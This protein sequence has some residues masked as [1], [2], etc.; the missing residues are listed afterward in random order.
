MPTPV[1]TRVVQIDPGPTPTLTM[2][3]PWSAQARTASPVATLPTISATCRVNRS[4]SL[5]GELEDPGRVAVG[6]VDGE[7]VDA[8]TR[9]APRPAPHPRADADGGGAQQA[10][11]GVLGRVRVLAD[12][13]DVLEGEHAGQPAVG[14]DDRQLLD[15]VRPASGRGPASSVVPGAAVT[16]PSAVM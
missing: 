15:P 11:A 14:V 13:L 4:L 6:G 2:S 3:A 7:Q 8:R 9:P 1:T 5:A 12:L 10:P 16:S